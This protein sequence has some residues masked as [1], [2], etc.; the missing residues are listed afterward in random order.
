M[1]GAAIPGARNGKK[2]PLRQDRRGERL[3]PERGD[4]TDHKEQY[5]Y[6]L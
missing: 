6:H 1:P 3:A 5:N 2:I 4:Q